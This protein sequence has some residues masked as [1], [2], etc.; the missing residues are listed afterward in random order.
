MCHVLA[1]RFRGNYICVF[2]KI[3]MVLPW[4]SKQEKLGLGDLKQKGKPQ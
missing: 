2:K 4:H 3:Q 1:I